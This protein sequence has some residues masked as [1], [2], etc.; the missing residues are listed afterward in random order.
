MAKPQQETPLS[1]TRSNTKQPRGKP[2]RPLPATG[3]VLRSKAKSANTKMTQHRRL[4]AGKVAT[5][6][7]KSKK[8]DDTGKYNAIS[9]STNTVHSHLVIIVCFGYFKLV[10]W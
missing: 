10:F 5:R 4:Q 6:D 2:R 1:Q 8:Y 9:G 3:R 7:G